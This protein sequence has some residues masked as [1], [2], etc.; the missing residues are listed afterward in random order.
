MAL[1]SVLCGQAIVGWNEE[2]KVE[3]RKTLPAN[4]PTVIDK[5]Y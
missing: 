2:Q 4:C 5:E 1:I 3:K